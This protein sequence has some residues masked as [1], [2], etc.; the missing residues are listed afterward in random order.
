M[1]RFFLE[2]ITP[3]RV[4][5]RGDAEMIVLPAE[6][7]EV[8]IMAMHEPAVYAVL[9]GAMRIYREG[10]AREA[11]VSAGF[12]E[13]RPD[14]TVVLCQAVEWPEEIDER[15]AEEAARRAED[16]LRHRG[17]MREYRV[18]QAA[19]ARAFARLAVKGRSKKH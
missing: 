1:S 6:G 14:E 13:V 12:C 5:Y 8:G 9:P 4:F 11:F 16:R 3:E 2:I 7:G 10:K 17:S 19:L 15:Q 18:S